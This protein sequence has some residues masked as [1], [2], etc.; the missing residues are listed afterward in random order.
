MTVCQ[1]MESSAKA[2]EGNPSTEPPST[3]SLQSRTRKYCD[4]CNTERHTEDYCWRKH[5]EKRPA[6]LAQMSLD[7]YSSKIVEEIRDFLHESY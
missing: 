3:L 4:F 1:K 7:L 2:I 5:P 6:S